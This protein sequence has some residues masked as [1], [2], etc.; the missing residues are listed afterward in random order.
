MHSSLLTGDITACEANDNNTTAKVQRADRTVENFAA[1]N[2]DHN[3][4]ATTS[5][6]FMSSRILSRTSSLET[7]MT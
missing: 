6:V 1:N 4:N 7:S 2:F 3:I 5:K